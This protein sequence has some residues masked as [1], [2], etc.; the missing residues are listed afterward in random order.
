MSTTEG[1]LIV[2]VIVLIYL[3]WSG[4]AKKGP[5]IWNCIKDG[6]SGAGHPVG[7]KCE[8]CVEKAAM[9]ETQEH[10]TICRDPNIG[11]QPDSCYCGDDDKF[12]YAIDEFGAPGMEYK[13]WVTSQAVDNNVIRNHAEFVR[14]RLGKNGIWTGR[15]WT[16]DSSFHESYLSNAVPWMG[17]RGP[18]QRVAVC[19]PSQ[20]T[21]IDP[22]VLPAKQKLTWT[23]S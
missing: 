15:T 4:K 16:P 13:D 17:I 7:C 19:N 6:L 3:V 11:V 18:P 2:I 23:T 20:V 9:E 10:F 22:E 8:E 14:D 21:D 1:I 5:V 12:A